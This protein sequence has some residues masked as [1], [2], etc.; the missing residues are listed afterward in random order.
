MLTS[1]LLK[2]TV[3]LPRGGCRVD[4]AQRSGLFLY[5]TGTFRGPPKPPRVSSVP[6]APV[7]PQEEHALPAGLTETSPMTG[8]TVA[9][10]H[11][12]A[13]GDRSSR[14]AAD[15]GASRT[16]LSATPGTLRLEL[17]ARRKAMGLRDAEV[18]GAE[19]SAEWD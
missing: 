4:S 1:A 16:R 12:S 5:A 8:I 2:E 18:S 3:T 19:D 7:P 14:T 11:Y 9:D 10:V 17:Q 15:F 6:A 13:G